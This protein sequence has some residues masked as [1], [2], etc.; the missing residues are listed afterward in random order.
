MVENVEEWRMDGR[1]NKKGIIKRH[2]G[3]RLCRSIKYRSD[4]SGRARALVDDMCG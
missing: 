1:P 3:I 4:F 2:T